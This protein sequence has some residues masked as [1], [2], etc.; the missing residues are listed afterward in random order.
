MFYTIPP[1]WN[2]YELIDSGNYKKIERFNNIIII[3]PEP[4]ALWDTSF[5]LREW[6]Q[7]AHLEYVPE[8][9][10]KGNWK[11]IKNAPDNWNI[12]YPL[13]GNPKNNI[14]I[15]IKLSSFKNIGIFPEQAY[16]WEFLWEVNNNS[17]E[18]LNILNLFAYTGVASIICAKAGA[19]V[20]H[21][22][23]LKSVVSQASINAKL[24]NI[25]NI[26]WIIDDAVKFV[27]REIKRKK[28]YNGIILDPPA[29]GHGTKGELWKLEDDLYG[30]MKN[31]YHIIHK[32]N[33][34]LLLNVYSLGLSAI[35]L[36]NIIK[37]IFKPQNYTI[38]ELY[39]SDK[40][41]KKLPL[42]VFV[43]INNVI[44]K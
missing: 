22:D 26:R 19:L 15:N 5:N 3:R 43:Q 1:Y 17:K 21:V 35:V 18:K 13:A 27:K 2:D 8:T 4:Q 16:N 25:H 30:L 9:S 37:L 38:G 39:I 44:N 20:T 23:S 41:N 10:N 11:K 40:F 12:G 29:F 31:L 28:L 24:N 36:E 33:Y 34:F 14:I 32:D 42:G 6:Y 7:I